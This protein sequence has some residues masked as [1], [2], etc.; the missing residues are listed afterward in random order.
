[1]IRALFLFLL[2]CC[3]S[4]W[5]H[6]SSE[7]YLR[8]R[9]DGADVEQRLDIALRDLDRDLGL[10]A[11]GDGTLAWGE[12]R[13]RWADIE[14]L[15]DEGVR[16]TA[17]GAA[18]G[19]QGRGES[20]LDEHSDGMHAVLVTRW[21]C[22]A[23]VHELAI[24]YRLF[25]ATDAGHRGLA[26]LVGTSGEPLLLQ[27]GA[28]PQTLKA[29]H[30]GLADFVIEGMAH[31]ASGLDHVLF[32]V[33]LLLVAVWKRDGKGW[34]PRAGAR[35]AFGE[36]LRLVTAFTVAHSI[37]L[38]LAAGGVIDP[39]SRWIESLI[40]LTVLL[41][42][43]DNIRP[44][45]PGPRWVTVGVFGLV[46]GVGFAGPLKD[47]G[48]RGAELLRPLLG[49]NVGVELGQLGVVVLLLPAALALRRRA[50]YRR[51]IVPGGSSAIAALAA[52]WLAERSLALQLLP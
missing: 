31:I 6:Q 45:V 12:V 25:A 4:A 37:T 5:A 35:S 8:Y 34:A 43:L 50:A 21:H 14:K 38:G 2:L 18:C 13:G 22:A 39:P 52:L 10:D 40:A 44:F 36:T 33:T 42:A 48:L 19:L 41:A 47:L 23:A 29:E 16:F 24:D 17:G 32:L 49:F 30:A 11:D 26:R 9:V 7:A 46:H 1:V 3:T 27:P 51:W 15:A 28:G 20:Q